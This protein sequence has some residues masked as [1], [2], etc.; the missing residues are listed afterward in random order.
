M[1]QSNLPQNK[2]YILPF[3]YKTAPNPSVLMEVEIRVVKNPSHEE[4]GNAVFIWIAII[5]R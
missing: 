5:I 2:K 4:Y 3:Y 1:N